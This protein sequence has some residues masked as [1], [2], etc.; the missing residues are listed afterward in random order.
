[1]I[2][3]EFL[4]CYESGV[5]FFM[6][7]YNLYKNSYKRDED[8]DNEEKERENNTIFTL[9]N[10]NVLRECIARGFAVRGY[11]VTAEVLYKNVND[12]DNQDL[13]IENKEKQKGKSGSLDLLIIDEK[14]QDENNK[15]YALELKIEKD[16]DT[17]GSGI[18]E[19]ISDAHRLVIDKENNYRKKI[20]D[21]QKYTVLLIDPKY[22]GE[23]SGY[24][25][26]LLKSLINKNED[27]E[28][29]CN[30]ISKKKMKEIK[31]TIKRKITIDDSNN[32]KI[33]IILFKCEKN[34]PDNDNKNDASNS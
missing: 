23:R 33:E 4:A 7:I 1:M 22:I 28:V 17:C 34:K 13:Q 14:E 8:K 26:T 3:K 15:Y 25:E 29:D 5:S 9:L 12:K 30:E 10:E 32:N 11:K 20:Q 24:R 18:R 16:K 21:S 27:E 31:L 6:E 19:M 2:E